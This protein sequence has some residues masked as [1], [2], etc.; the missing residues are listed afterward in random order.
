MSE[1]RRAAELEPA[2]SATNRCGSGRRRRARQRVDA[3]KGEI[4]GA[5]ANGAAKPTTPRA[6]GRLW[7]RP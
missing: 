1:K 2:R 6:L 7:E 4:E 5:V 3:L